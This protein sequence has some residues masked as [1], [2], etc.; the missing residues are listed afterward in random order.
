VTNGDIRKAAE[1]HLTGKNRTV[2]DVL[3][4]QGGN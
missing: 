4:A 2:L 1:T 3:P